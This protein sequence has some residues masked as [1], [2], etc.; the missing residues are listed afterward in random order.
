MSAVGS[1]S[2][3][4]G[5]VAVGLVAGAAGGVATCNT[6]AGVR[7]SQQAGTFE[8]GEETQ[9]CNHSDRQ[10]MMT[11]RTFTFLER[12][13]ESK[14][15]KRFLRGMTQHIKTNWK[16]QDLISLCLAVARRVPSS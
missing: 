15:A 4:V 11:L 1:C 6:A 13:R 3:G 2:A 7:S 10:A 5:A 9:Q 8:S 16:M 12:E 14:H